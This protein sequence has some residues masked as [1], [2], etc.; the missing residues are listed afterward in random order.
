MVLIA[1]ADCG[2]KAF[3]MPTIMRM[4]VTSIIRN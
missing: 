4:R 1:R 2:H 3:W